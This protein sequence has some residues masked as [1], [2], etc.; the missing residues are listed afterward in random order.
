MAGSSGVV[1]YSPWIR[2]LFF[3]PHIVI[4]FDFVWA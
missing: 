3:N 2:C 1:Q 4:L